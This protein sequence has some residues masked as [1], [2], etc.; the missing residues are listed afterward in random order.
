MK[1]T[2]MT[3]TLMLLAV[4]GCSEEEPTAS[5]ESVLRSTVTIIVAGP[6]GERHGSGF[7]TSSD[8]VIVTAAHVIDGVTSAV[9]RFQN[10]VELEVEGVIAIDRTK[11]YAVVRVAG[12]DLPTVS[13]GNA[14]SVSVGQRVLAIG[15]P[16]DTALAGTVSDGLV[17][18]ERLVDGLKMLQMSVPVSPGSSGGPVVTEQGEVIGLVV[19]GFSGSDIQNVNFALPINY[20]RGE[21]ALGAT[22][23]L[24]AFADIEV[25]LPVVAPSACATVATEDIASVWSCAEQGYA[26]AQGRVG[27][28]YEL[29]EGVPQ[30]FVLA[31]MWYTLAAD[32]GDVIAQGNKD[33]LERSCTF[34]IVTCRE[35]MLEAEQLVREWR[36]PLGLQLAPDT[37]LQS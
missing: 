3:L 37:A 30:N 23:L 13:L 32:Q 16:V 5:L 7:I 4:L 28:W 6:D 25:A 33:L 11:D 20:V 21:L 18:G 17:A 15:A 2:A 22:K 9:V 14:D 31:L 12:F 34:S 35:W 29:G 19:S 26:P 24:Q 36:Y 1:K 27:R 10:G 8:G